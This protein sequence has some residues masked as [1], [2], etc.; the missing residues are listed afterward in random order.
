MCS[1][2]FDLSHGR[3]L[4]EAGM[5]SGNRCWTRTEVDAAVAKWN[6]DFKLA[7]KNVMELTEDPSYKWLAGDGDGPAGAISGLTKREA[8]PALRAAEDL[9]P[10]L[11][12]L[13]QVLDEVN[14]RLKKLPI[15]GASQG[16][17]EIQNLLEDRSVKIATPTA[18]EQR[19]LLSP[20]KATEM[21]TPAEILTRMVEGYDRAKSV[22]LK[23]GNAVSKLRSELARAEA[24]I[25]DLHS[26]ADSQGGVPP[27]LAAVEAKLRTLEREASSDPLAVADGFETE[28]NRSLESIG[29]NLAQIQAERARIVKELESG[30]V[31]L[32]NLEHTFA[33]AAALH[34]EQH[35]K[36]ALEEKHI[37]RALFGPEV[38]EE[39]KNWLARI[40]ATLQQGRWRA[41]DV[42][43]H[44]WN[45]QADQRVAECRKV[46]DEC[47]SALNRR[48]ELRGLLDSLR[49]KAV[50]TGLAE[51]EAL[52]ILYQRAYGL[53]H[54]RPTPMAEAEKL[55]SE[56]LSAVR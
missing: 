14:E 16:L 36:V 52:D 13:Q 41:A 21:S 23:I 42:G 46:A 43:I 27:E 5:L 49:A 17:L 19:G 2:Y 29:R 15:F 55:V 51:D 26:I 50:D 30:A 3:D 10:L 38:V 18:Y 34:D 37:P 1:A 40:E 44:N 33:R 12:A 20:D 25:K 22:V 6:R 48:R 54:S 53:L 32:R 11:T 56:Y 31:S 35:I 4:T 28:V 7:A 24:E 39:L 9:W 45:L 8:A 47:G